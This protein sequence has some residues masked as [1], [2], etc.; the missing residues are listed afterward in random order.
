[1]DKIKELR[2]LARNI[3][4]GKFRVKSYLRLNKYYGLFLK[5]DSI[6]VNG[7]F[8]MSVWYNGEFAT[9]VYSNKKM[10][11]LNFGGR[12]YKEVLDIMEEEEK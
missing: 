1:M 2:R 4:S 12:P 11:T 7:A 9:W 10:G 8:G 6:Y 5:V 3:E